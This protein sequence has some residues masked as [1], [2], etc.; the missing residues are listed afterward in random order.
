[1]KVWEVMT[2]AVKSCSA[3]D[4][5]DAAAQIMWDNDCGCVPVVDDDRRVVGIIT[6]RD[7]CMAAH[8]QGVALKDSQAA[9]AMS[10]EVFTCDADAGIS[11]AEAIMRE[12]RVRRLPVVN[13]DN[14]LI[15]VVSL[16]DIAREGRREAARRTVRQVM[17][18][19]I[20]SVLGAVCQPR[21]MT[22][23][24]QAA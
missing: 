9:S 20:A 16:N 8:L 6:D 13:G 10:K 4:S 17:D 22:E 2:R 19:D 15:G 1:M 21:S 5:L 24:V 23:A 11:S 7:I 12:R 14:R 3:A 18:A